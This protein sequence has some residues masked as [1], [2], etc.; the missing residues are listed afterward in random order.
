MAPSLDLP[1]EDVERMIEVM[2]CGWAKGT[3]TTYG[4]GLLVYMVFCDDRGVPEHMRCPA[5][6]ILLTLFI[7]RCAGFYSGSTL[8]NYFFGVKAWHTLHGHDLALD[9]NQVRIALK[10]AEA[11][12]P[13]SSRREKREPF[14]TDILHAILLKL[15]PSD[16]LDA[17]VAACLCITFFAVAQV[18]EL[19][20]PAL[21]KFDPAKHA[22]RSDLRPEK[23]RSGN[24][25]T[26][27]KLPCTKT[28]P[29]A[30]EDIFW[31]TQPGSWDPTA[32]LQAHFDLNETPLNAH[33]FAYKWKPGQ[34]RPLTRKAFLDRIHSAS[35]GAGLKP[36]QGHGLRIGGTLE[37]LLRGVPFDVVK[38]LG[39]WSSEA[40]TRYLRKH[41]VILA[42]Y[43]QGT[44]FLEPFTRIMMPN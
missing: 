33:I 10:G 24:T 44:D 38:S 22:K 17:A 8:A 9:D 43:L 7:S 20:V 30:G 31:A 39:R 16:P 32:R 23:D 42:P 6:T 15:N 3:M 26:A 35:V 13:P 2:C 14:T 1:D 28:A 5:S 12:A 40:F 19:T 34:W 4:S 27:C 25:V 29:L 37:Y 41:A 36:L 18:G 11:L 21:N